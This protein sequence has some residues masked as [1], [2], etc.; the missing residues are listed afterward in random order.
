MKK[1]TSLSRNRWCR[2]MRCHRAGHHLQRP[3]NKPFRQVPL[4]IDA[5][6]TNNNNKTL[7]Y[8]RR[9]RREERGQSHP[10]AARFQTER[11]DYDFVCLPF[12]FFASCPA[13]HSHQSRVLDGTAVLSVPASLPLRYT[14]FTGGGARAEAGAQAEAESHSRA[15]Q[16]TPLGK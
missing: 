15:S 11:C 6:N 10:H 12:F 13:A 14:P 16:K 7:R 5:R 3:P 4:T 1:W 8:V 2:R 9:R